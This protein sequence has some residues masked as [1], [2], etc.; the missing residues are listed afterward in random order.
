MVHHAYVVALAKIEVCDI[1]VSN[2]LRGKVAAVLDAGVVELPRLM[3]VLAARDD[4][5]RLDGKGGPG[6]AAASGAGSPAT[7]GTAGAAAAGAA[8]APPPWVI[9]VENVL[10]RT[11]HEPP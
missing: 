4:G 6:T 5:K 9:L 11:Q 10:V 1:A 8:M 2:M 3:E 7:A